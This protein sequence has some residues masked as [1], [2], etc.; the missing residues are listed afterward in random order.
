M[1]LTAPL[2]GRDGN[3][4][5]AAAASRS[6][7]GE[8]RRRSLSAVLGRHMTD[9]RPLTAAAAVIGICL[10]ASGA[11]ACQPI[12]P[13]FVATKAQAFFVGTIRE[14]IEEGPFRADIEKGGGTVASLSRRP[15]L[16]VP[17]GYLPDCSDKPWGEGEWR[18]PG[19][20]G[21]FTGQL[22][23]RSKWL[24]GMPTIDV[25]LAP[26]QPE[27]ATEDPRWERVNDGVVLLTV[28]EFFDF[29][30]ALPPAEIVDERP[31]DALVRLERW[32]K[33]HPELALRE[34]VRMFMAT[35]RKRAGIARVLPNNRYLDSSGQVI[36]RRSSR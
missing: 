30:S 21:F 8:R 20:R 12:W 19:T 16:L 22:R 24:K 6:P 34:P 28:E 11:W 31:K 29:Y 26:Q 35:L 32:T 4:E 7:F 25:Y 18:P 5:V 27:W 23:P 17:W 15:A 10:S 36:R 14:R 13:Q 1:K 9:R 3:V 2:G 33:K